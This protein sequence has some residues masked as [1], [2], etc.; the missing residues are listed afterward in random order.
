MNLTIVV[1]EINLVY[2]GL[3]IYSSWLTFV[4]SAVKWKSMAACGPRS[5][6]L[7]YDPCLSGITRQLVTLSRGNRSHLARSIDD[8]WSRVSGCGLWGTLVNDL[9]YISL[10]N[11]ARHVIQRKLPATLRWL[12]SLFTVQSSVSGVYSWLSGVHSYCWESAL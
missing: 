3:N 7:F 4:E 9:F 10:G 1:L 2:Y 8:A 5:D 11:K 6:Y 12:A